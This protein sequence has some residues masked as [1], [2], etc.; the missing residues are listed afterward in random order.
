MAEGFTLIELL[1]V[2]AIIGVV[3][4]IAIPSLL[5]ARMTGNEASAIGSLRALN[6]AEVAYSSACG[7]NGFATSFLVLGVA[8]PGSADGFLSP[9]LA[10]AAAPSKSGYGFTIAPSAA[11]AAGL[12]DCNGVP[13][14]SGYYATG[15]PLSFGSTGNRSFATSAEATIWQV[16]APAAPAEPFG[17]PATPIQ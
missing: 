8:P 2:V 14:Q 5:R 6:T 11:S 7:R 1:V 3:A 10:S 12:P 17:A 4:A 13:T 16:P 9:D 15:T